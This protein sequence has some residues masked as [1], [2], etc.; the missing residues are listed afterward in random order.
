MFPHQRSL[1]LAAQSD[2]FADTERRILSILHLATAYLE[3]GQL[4]HRFIIFPL[5][6]AG[7]ATALPDVKVQV[8]NLVKAFE[9]S[10]VGGNTY[11]TRRLL[12]TVLEE[13]RRVVGEG[14]RMEDVDWLRVARERGL[15]VVNCGL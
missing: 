15:G 11:T 3:T 2:I 9:G 1:P 14:G 13:Q 12:S 6:I 8:L 7:F 5:F 4:H 10:A